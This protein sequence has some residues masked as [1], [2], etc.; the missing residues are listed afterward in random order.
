MF[1][2][3]AKKLAEGLIHQIVDID[4]D[5]VVDFACTYSAVAYLIGG[6]NKS[7]ASFVPNKPNATGLIH[8]YKQEGSWKYVTEDE[9]EA[10]KAELPKLTYATRH[11][12]QGFNDKVF[13]DLEAL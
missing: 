11:S 4:A 10:K 7:P 9:F 3:S 12:I 2:S 5:K 6:D 1:G 13:A 8:F